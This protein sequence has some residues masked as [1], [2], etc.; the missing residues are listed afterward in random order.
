MQIIGAFDRSRVS[1]LEPRENSILISITSNGKDFPKVNKHWKDIL[2]LRFNDTED[3]DTG[4]MTSHAKM[5]LDFV[6]KHIDCDIFVNCDA[7]ISRSTGVV[8]ALELLFNSKDISDKYPYH[9]RHVKNTIRDMWFK[10]V[11]K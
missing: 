6:I 2:Q 7:G 9:N 11:W 4:M 10:S 3:R 5:I 1:D 8:V